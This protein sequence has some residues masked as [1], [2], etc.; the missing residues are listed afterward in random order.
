MT[1]CQAFSMTSSGSTRSSSRPSFPGSCKT[2]VE[3]GGGFY[4]YIRERLMDERPKLRVRVALEFLAT[5]SFDC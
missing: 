2:F 1:D 3:F 5:W 4:G